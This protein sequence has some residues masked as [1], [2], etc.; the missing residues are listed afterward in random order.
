M[1]INRETKT[2]LIILPFDVDSIVH[3]E[4]V[5]VVYKT[6]VGKLHDKCPTLVQTNEN[7]ATTNVSV[8]LFALILTQHNNSM[9]QNALIEFK[10][11]P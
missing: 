5:V 7:V 11:M 10:P 6:N 9:N 1:Q 2:E 3:R 8:Y 4:T